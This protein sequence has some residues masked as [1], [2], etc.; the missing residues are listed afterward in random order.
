MLTAER[1]QLTVSRRIRERSQKV[2]STLVILHYSY[3]KSF[4]CGLLANFFGNEMCR[5]CA[6]FCLYGKKKANENW[7]F[8]L[9]SRQPS[10][11]IEAGAAGGGGAG[12]LGRGLAMNVEKLV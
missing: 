7:R 5:N 8:K 2:I 4:V 10:E 11:K 1:L 6:K 9:Q 3:D 12:A